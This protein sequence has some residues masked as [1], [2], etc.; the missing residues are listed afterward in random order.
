MNNAIDCYGGKHMNMPTKERKGTIRERAVEAI[1]WSIEHHNMK[2]PS[3]EQIDDEMLRTGLHDFEYDLFI[4]KGTMFGARGNIKE[5]TKDS[6]L[7]IKQSN[8]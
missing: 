1:I 8:Y 5:T 2:A 4:P 3:F 6:T 7:T